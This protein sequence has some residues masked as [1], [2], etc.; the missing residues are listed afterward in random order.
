MTPDEI[1]AAENACRQLAL[2]HLTVAEAVEELNAIAI[3]AMGDRERL[4]EEVNSLRR[5]NQALIDN[6]VSIH[7]AA[8]RAVD[9]ERRLIID[10]LLLAEPWL[11]PEDVADE[12]ERNLHRK[13]HD[14]GLDTGFWKDVSGQ[15]DLDD[16]LKAANDKILADSP[17]HMT[18]SSPPPLQYS[19][20]D[21]TAV[22]LRDPKSFP[23]VRDDGDG[24]EG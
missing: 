7:K 12:I 14:E 22:P 17:H 3:R 23:I 24:E 1:E 5:Q 18:G 4:Q 20:R 10:H 6:G 15:L 16:P 19:L 13:P 9:E 21:D 11:S 2:G 8:A